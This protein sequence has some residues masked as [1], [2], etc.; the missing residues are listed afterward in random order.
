MPPS[1]R[2]AA[3]LATD[4]PVPAATYLDRTGPQPV[5]AH[6]NKIHGQAPMELLRQLVL[7]LRM[8]RPDVVLT[9][10]A[11]GNTA[12][13]LVAE[14]MVEAVKQANDP[15][16]FPEQIE[17]L[18]LTVCKVRSLYGR[19]APGPWSTGCRQ[20]FVRAGVGSIGPGLR[21]SSD[22]AP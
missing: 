1:A 19:S 21:R 2:S 12:E 17:A 18:G 7:T 22:R 4:E 15:T 16:A 10:P 9:D 14:A 11:D 8:W 5:L 6:W 20:H 3:W 13:A